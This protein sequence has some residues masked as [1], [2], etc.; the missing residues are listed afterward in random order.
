[1]R[2]SM[3]L[4]TLAFLSL[5]GCVGAVTAARTRPEV[6]TTGRA[7]PKT[8]TRSVLVLSPTVLADVGV[9]SA[10]PLRDLFAA[11][12]AAMER[13][14]FEAG[15]N[16]IDKPAIVKLVTTHKV[17]LNIRQVTGR[18]G[19][20][21]IDIAGTLGPASTADTVL[22]VSGWRTSWQPVMIDRRDY[23]YAA[24]LCTLAAELHV[25]LHDR[26]GRL[27]W[28]ATSRGRAT[29]MYDL[30]IV[31]NGGTA[32][33][34]HPQ[35][36]CASRDGNCSDCPATVDESAIRAMATDTAHAVVKDLA[37]R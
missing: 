35:Y 15:W 26:G 34:S 37:G 10:L 24:H 5:I 20:A 16:P 2:R 36:A 11:P 33:V 8:A 12:T 21:L 27:L 3:L 6:E 4:V 19:A 18:E 30:T 7:V 9:E 32:D 25:S 17:A 29:D 14:L 1:M 31:G 28:E 23:G 13:E 22:L